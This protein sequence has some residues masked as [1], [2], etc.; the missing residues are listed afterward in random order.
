METSADHSI[1]KKLI[2]T[3]I[4]QETEDFKTFQL[5]DENEN[6][7]IYHAGQYLTLVN[8]FHGR[9]E[10]RC[11]SLTSSP[12]LQ[13]PLTIGVKRISNG[14]FSRYLHDHIS[15]G[16]TLLTTGAAGMFVLPTHIQ[17]I[18]TIYLFAAGSG[19]TPIFSLLKTILYAHP[20]IQVVLVYSN[21]SPQTTAFLEPL[22][23]YSQQFTDRL[24]IHF[25]YSNDKN[26]F[27]AHL[28]RDLLLQIVNTDAK[29]SRKGT[30]AY[31]CGPLS[32][33]RMCLYTLRE[34]GFDDENVKKETFDT[35]PAP[36]YHLPPDKLTRR[37]QIHL[38]GTTHNLEVPYP[39]SILQAAKQS[40]IFLPYSCEA[41]KC[42]S[43]TMRCTHG[44]VWMS[45]NEVLTKND[46]EKGLV[47][48]CTGHPVNGDVVLH[49]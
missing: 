24:L 39:K 44:D 2:V 45:Y 1:C 49:G 47:L 23:R 28:H 27:R 12:H 20:H 29:P 9:E 13:E 8:C 33:R 19:I 35:T 38:N 10:R 14:V 48:T 41:G 5:H 37:V 11:Y 26:I 22:Q 6:R 40:G 3:A 30:L 7:I 4:G 46:I 31:V 16:D 21:H 34:A 36:V 32:Y 42:G 18:E 15:V 17:E 43:C 25:L